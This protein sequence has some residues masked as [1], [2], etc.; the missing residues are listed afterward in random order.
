[1]ALR[2]DDGKRSFHHQRSVV[3]QANSHFCHG[4]LSVCGLKFGDPR[5][6]LPGLP[7][8]GQTCFFPIRFPWNRQVCGRKMRRT[9]P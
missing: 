7:A 6:R 2:V 8:R 1:V 3:S 9:T 4:S 5:R